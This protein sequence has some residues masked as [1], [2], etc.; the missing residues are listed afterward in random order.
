VSHLE[1]LPDRATDLPR[2][3]RVAPLPGKKC[4]LCSLASSNASTFSSQTHPPTR[5]H[6]LGSDC[7]PSIADYS[8]DSLHVKFTL[9]PK[10]HVAV[11]AIPRAGAQPV[12]LAVP[13]L[14]L[15]V[16]GVDAGST[17]AGFEGKQHLYVFYGSNTGACEAFAQKIAS[18]APANGAY[19]IECTYADP[20]YV[21]LRRLCGKARHAGCRGAPATERRAGRGHHRVIRGRT[22]GQRSSFCLVAVRP[23]GR[24]A[25]GRQ[26][27]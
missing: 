1:K 5:A 6:H 17:D 27:Q 18:A 3:N 24:R 8:C 2:V 19:C 7:M 23:R 14:G 10:P 22:G 15:H 13:S 16:P 21:T 12:L 11:R 9:T 25:C 4:I 20:S 26:L